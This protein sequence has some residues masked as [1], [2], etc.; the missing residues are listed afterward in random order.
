M[1]SPRTVDLNADVGEASDTTGIA[2]ERDLLAYVTSVH[3]ACGGHAGDAASM[4][5]TVDAALAAGV[6]VGAHPSFPDRDGFGRRPMAME[7]S[8][9]VASLRT[10]L[11]AFHEVTRAAGTTV[12]SVK[13]HGALYGEIGRGG[14]TS[15]AFIELVREMWGGAVHLVLP[16]GAPALLVAADLGC[17]VLEEGFCDRAYR[18]DGTLVDRRQP[19]AVLSDA[20]QAAEQARALVAR[21]Q[22][23][24]SDG[25]WL[26]LHVDTLCLHGDTPDAVAIAHAVRRALETDG[27]VMAAPA[28]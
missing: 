26:D 6:R 17:P 13:P 12:D 28:L 18:P 2:I 10:Q 9:L 14:P 4:R 3:V 23:R 25:G 24:D 20:S 22:V 11:S 27:V 5:A 16:A 21:G 8:D 1:T 7:L 15:I 19:G